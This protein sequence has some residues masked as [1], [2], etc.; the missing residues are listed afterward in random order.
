MIALGA[1]LLLPAAGRAQ[2]LIHHYQFAADASDSVGGANGTLLNGATA[3]G[4]VL[5]LNAGTG[6]YVQFGS[7]I[8]PTSGSYSVALFAR[9][10]AAPSGIIELISQGFSGGPG[11]Y[12]GYAA[13]NFRVTDS[14]IN[15]GVAFPTDTA[16]FH[17]IAMSVDATAGT[18]SL[19]VDGLLQAT[20]GTAITTTTGGTDTR[21]GRQF[22]PF[23]EFFGG[24]MRDVRVYTGALSAGQ[25]AALAAGTA[26]VPE[27]GS[28][29]L[30][31]VAV[32]PG[33]A[34]LLSRRRRAAAS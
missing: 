26:S 15:T 34:L 17:H 4:G 27:P 20:L 12:I 3:A 22:D 23:Q 16:L 11:F 29:A 10:N 21:L 6:S 2:T 13:P 9:Q 14:W 25:V 5:S 7:H 18:S 8:V 30:A 31:G 24:Q 19:Y 1:L 28:A 33:L 32:L